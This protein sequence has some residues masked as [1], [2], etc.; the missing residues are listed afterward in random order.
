MFAVSVVLLT[1]PTLV[2]ALPPMVTVAPL[3]KLLPVMMIAVAPLVLP[4]LGAT[5]TTTGGE[6]ITPRFV[7]FSVMNSTGQVK[8][9][10]CPAVN[11]AILLDTTSRSQRVS[12]L[13]VTVWLDTNPA[14]T[15]AATVLVTMR[16]RMTAVGTRLGFNRKY[17]LTKSLVSPDKVTPS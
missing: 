9:P 1:K 13:T 15:V 17:E 2:A 11:E 14:A 16:Q 10:V 4:Q 8:V 6:A 5:D 7:M 3:T 12:A